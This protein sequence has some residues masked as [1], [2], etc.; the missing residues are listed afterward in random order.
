[1]LSNDS[2]AAAL[3]CTPLG[4]SDET[5]IAPVTPAEW[6]RV[7]GESQAAPGEL[8]GLEAEEIRRRLDCEQQLADRLA[9]LLGG[10]DRLFVR[11]DRFASAGIW[12]LTRFDELF[13]SRLIKRLGTRC[14]MVVFGAGREQLLS[15]GGVAI[16]GARNMSEGARQFAESAGTAAAAA[17]MTVISGGA[18]G[19]D[20][21]AMRAAVSAGGSALGVLADSLERA[22]RECETQQLMEYGS[23]C[24]ITAY[25][26]SLPFSVANA[27]GRNKIIYALSDYALVVD[28]D[29][30][31]G[32]TWNGAI[33]NLRH[34]LAPLFV[35]ESADS[36]PG[37][38]HLIR[39]GA[40]ALTIA[41]I[42]SGYALPDFLESKLRARNDGQCTNRADERLLRLVEYLQQPHRTSEISEALGL[43]MAATRELIKEALAANQIVRIKERPVTYQAGDKVSGGDLFGDGGS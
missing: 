39:R 28:S 16:V 3:L 27:M 38:Q 26:P 24:V 19:I 34:G 13:P 29:Y 12:M 9:L 37:N 7:I 8:L 14:P 35:R 17:G 40:V 41:E 11:L 21:E 15:G 4:L 5:V 25:S 31:K 2:L 1:M 10:S 36:S 20:Q 43:S 33:E 30:E 18:R 22:I 6:Q 32:G 42:R 23:L